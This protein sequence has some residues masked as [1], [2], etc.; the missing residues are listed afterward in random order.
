M[1]VAY[2]SRTARAKFLSQPR[3]EWYIY[4]IMKVYFP[5]VVLLTKSLVIQFCYIDTR[6]LLEN[7]LLVKLIK[8][9]SRTR[10]VYFP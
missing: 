1:V 8:T 2:E 9:R 7:I 10:V 3:M 4:S 6:F 5:L